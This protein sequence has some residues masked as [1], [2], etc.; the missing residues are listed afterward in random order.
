MTL[1]HIHIVLLKANTFL[2]HPMLWVG[3][4]F[5][6]PIFFSNLKSDLTVVRQSPSP[7][8]WEC[9]QM[10]L[11]VCMFLCFEI[12]YVC[13]EYIYHV[14]LICI[15]SI[16]KKTTMNNLLCLP[17]LYSLN[18]LKLQAKYSECDTECCHYSFYYLYIFQGRLYF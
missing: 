1:F 12:C 9:F 13:L 10:S 17:L 11:Y 8:L 15:V 4:F 5:L 6:F 7:C 3:Q 14:Q 18:L 16:K 2:K